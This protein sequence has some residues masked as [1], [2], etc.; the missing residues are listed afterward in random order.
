[1]EHI[2]FL[3]LIF[4]GMAHE[5]TNAQTNCTLCPN[6]DLTALKDI[7]KSP[8]LS[9]FHTLLPC[10]IIRNIPLHALHQSQRGQGKV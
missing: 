6:I 9:H 2:Y 1:M 5:Q 3:E 8:T 10:S 4:W 7:R